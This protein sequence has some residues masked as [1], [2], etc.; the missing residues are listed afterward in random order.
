MHKVKTLAK[1]AL[2]A[3]AFAAAWMP[4]YWLLTIALKRDLDQFADP[5][6]WFAF[7]P[8]LIGIGFLPVFYHG[9]E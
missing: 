2:A 5:P 1:Y 7:T 6:L 8:T 4:L 9:T 3:A